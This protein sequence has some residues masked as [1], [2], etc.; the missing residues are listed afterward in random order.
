MKEKIFTT[1][2]IANAL[3]VHPGTIARWVNT[4]KLKAMCTLGGH[5]RIRQSD[6]L[7]FFME[8]NMTCPQEL[9]PAAGKRKVLVVDD[10][11]KV[12]ALLAEALRK[13]GGFEVRTAGDWFEAGRMVGEDPPDVLVLD[14]FLPGVDGVR[15]CRMVKEEYPRVKV[16][17]IT[18]RDSRAVRRKIL[19]A[20]A[21]AY[22]AKP[23]D[24]GE[25]VSVVEGFFAVISG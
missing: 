12:S 24:P 4:G 15:A 8:N 11:E 13:R 10:D 20:G 9:I 5:K 23:F 16:V 14:V 2:E 1:R 21:D 19:D 25:L 7:E 17:A 22:L 3:G 6:L 18:G